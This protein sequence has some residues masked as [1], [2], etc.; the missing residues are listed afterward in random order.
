MVQAYT[1]VYFDIQPE[2]QPASDI[3]IAQLAEWPFESFE[4]TETGLNAYIPTVDFKPEIL[5]HIDI[6]QQAEFQI[7]YRF[8]NIEPVNWNETWEQ[9]FEPIRIDDRCII[10]ADFHPSENLPHDIVIT[11]KMSFGTG[12]HE[13]TYMMLTWLLDQDFTGKSVLDMGAGTAVLAILAA[14]RGAQP[15]VAIDNDPWCFENATENCQANHCESIEVV[16]GDA[17]AL[18]GRTFDVIIANINR[19]ILLQDMATYV[20]C[21]QPGG[22]LYLSGFYTHDI[23]AL[24]TCC[25]DLGLTYVG[26]KERNNWASLRFDRL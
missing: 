8:E 10:R 16:L 1:A 17:A 26:Q 5:N 15:V 7:S 14:Q 19:N 4:E 25:T 6:L 18:A 23:E 9:Q 11:P 22:Q 21:L 13:T 2:L 12:H 20:G 3:L 24:T